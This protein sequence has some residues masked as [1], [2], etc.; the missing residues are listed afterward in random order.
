MGE[1]SDI[2]LFCVCLC[3]CLGDENWHFEQQELS[4]V[5]DAYCMRPCDSGYTS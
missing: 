1:G 2:G 5:S 3:Q 4:G